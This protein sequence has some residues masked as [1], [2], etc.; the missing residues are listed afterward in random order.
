MVNRSITQTST[1]F[2][3]LLL[4]SGKY[5][6]TLNNFFS[7]YQTYLYTAINLAHDEAIIVEVDAA[8]S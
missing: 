5:Q 6:Q 1:S 7:G 4:I 3:C 8:Q 2:R